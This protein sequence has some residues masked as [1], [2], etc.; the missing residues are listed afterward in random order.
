MSLH[1][2]SNLDLAHAVMAERHRQADQ[3]R[4]ARTARSQRRTSQPR[5]GRPVRLVQ[6]AV[7]ALLTVLILALVLSSAVVTVLVETAGTT[8]P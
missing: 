8:H 5:T 7:A 6:P 4:L 1:P 3:A 2:T